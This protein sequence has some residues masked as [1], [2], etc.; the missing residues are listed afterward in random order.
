MGGGYHYLF[1]GMAKA[2]SHT[3]L[4]GNSNFILLKLQSYAVNTA[5]APTGSSLASSLIKSISTRCVCMSLKGTS[6]D[7]YKW[8]SGNNRANHMSNNCL[9][10]FRKKGS[11]KPS[12]KWTLTLKLRK[13]IMKGHA[14]LLKN[15][16]V[17]LFSSSL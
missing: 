2:P 12:S 10:Y 11:N 5:L 1:M 17:S 3:F 4:N 14:C 9:N 8:W 15:N 7:N 6:W 13:K 16:S